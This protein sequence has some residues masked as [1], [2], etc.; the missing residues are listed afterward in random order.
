MDAEGRVRTRTNRS[1]GVQGGLAN[2]EPIVVRV[3]FK[4]TSTIA[5]PQKT[6]SRDGKDTDLIARGRHDPG[7]VPRA[8][9]MVEAMVALTLA[10]HLLLHYAQCEL[11]PRG[12]D[13]VGTGSGGDHEGVARVV[14]GDASPGEL[15]GEDGRA[16]RFFVEEPARA[17][18]RGGAVG[19]G[20]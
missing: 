4:P 17:A 20:G 9:P 8:V 2:G 18:E 3:A 16:V 13:A 12:E 19:E 11:L 1:G 15:A 14:D 7:V 5:R 10:D 6:V